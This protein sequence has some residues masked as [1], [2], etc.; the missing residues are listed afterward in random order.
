MTK[1]MNRED[2]IDKYILPMESKDTVIAYLRGEADFDED[3]LQE[4][5]DSQELII[6]EGE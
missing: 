5:A 1:I 4:I 6:K 2:F 3:Y